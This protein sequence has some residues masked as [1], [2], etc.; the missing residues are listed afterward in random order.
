ML[1]RASVK[2]VLNGHISR[3]KAYIVVT[4][5]FYPR[6]FHRELRDEYLAV[7]APERGLFTEFKAKERTM[8]SHNPA[9]AAVNYEE[10]FW[11]NEDGMDELKRLSEKARDRDVF[12]I[13][14]CNPLQRCHVDLLLMIA[15]HFFQAICE[16][17][18]FDYPLFA[19]RLR[20]SPLRP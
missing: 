12:L 11:L 14:Q 20:K 17:P 3:E 10:R 8:K 19:E 6:F 1:M 13:C 7:L 2:D 9:F 16:K 5:R 18:R 4:M 15:A